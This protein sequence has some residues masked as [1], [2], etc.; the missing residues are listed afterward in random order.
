MWALSKPCPLAVGQHSS[1]SSDGQSA[2]SAPP[3]A[4]AVDNR[5][6]EESM[7]TVMVSV[8]G[9]SCRHDLR[10]ISAQLYDL[11]GVV[12]VE[13]DL[14]AKTIC[15]DGEVQVEEVRAA[16]AGAGYEVVS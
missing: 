11:D 2:D 14:D 3:H 4:R 15:V 1:P 16:I 6:C 5:A 12:A 8:P 13:V 10:T 9:M 7:K